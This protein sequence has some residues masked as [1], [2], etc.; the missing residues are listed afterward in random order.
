MTAADI[1]I[2]VL[3]AHRR[4]STGRVIRGSDAVRIATEAADL[5]HQHL[6]LNEADI[7]A[8]QMARAAALAGR[9]KD[10][11]ARLENWLSVQLIEG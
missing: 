10:C 1:L 6:Q 4:V 3:A 11:L 7:L 9:P 5:A 2:L 8:L